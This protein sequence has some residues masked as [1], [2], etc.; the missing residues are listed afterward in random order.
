MRI[1]VIG[2]ELTAGTGDPR[3]L[4]WVGRVVAHSVFEET[5]NVMT[6]PVPGETTRDMSAR[7]ESEAVLRLGSSGTRGLVVAV[8]AAD[9][10]AGVSSP[11]SR[12][13]LANITDRAAALGIPCF[14]VGP[15]PL[16]GVDQGA[17]RALSASCAQ[18]CERR[19]LPFVDVFTPLVAHDQWFEDMAASRARTESGMTLPGQSGY[20]L[21][22]WLVLHQGWHEWTGAEP[23]G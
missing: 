10:P 5:T 11:R 3:G 7:W 14:V 19:G 22:A 8:G 4:G 12:L 18:V 16:A 17:L 13:N 1:C 15:P 2:D 20:A 9:V 23:R 21:M 6:L